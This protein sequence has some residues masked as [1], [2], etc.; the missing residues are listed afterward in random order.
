MALIVSVFMLSACSS[1]DEPAK[2]LEGEEMVNHIESV[3]T[4]YLENMYVNKTFDLYLLPVESETEAREVVRKIICKTWDDKEETFQVPG[5]CGR[6]RMIQGS[7]EGVYY[8]LVFDVTGLKHFSLQLCM[9]GYPEN[10]NLAHS[11]SH[12]KETIGYFYCSGCHQ[13]TTRDKNGCCKKCGSDKVTMIGGG[14]FR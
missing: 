9:S 4:G 7:E 8:T 13:E 11:V 1:D 2:V 3:L 14:T 6:I 5:N 12:I 10:D